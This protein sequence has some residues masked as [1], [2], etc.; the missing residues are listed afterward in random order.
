MSSIKQQLERCDGLG[1]DPMGMNSRPDKATSTT[2]APQANHYE[3]RSEERPPSLGE[4]M[5][6]RLSQFYA[7]YQATCSTASSA[8]QRIIEALPSRR[9]GI[10][11]DFDTSIP[12]DVQAALV[13]VQKAH[14]AGTRD[15]SASRIVRAWVMGFV[16]T[17]PEATVGWVRD[18]LYS[19]GNKEVSMNIT[20]PKPAPLLALPYYPPANRTA[21]NH[22]A[23][24][25]K[26]KPA[27]TP[28]PHWR[29][30]IEGGIFR[31][32][33]SS[34]QI[35]REAQ[36]RAAAERAANAALRTKV[37]AVLYPPDDNP[38][39]GFAI[40]DPDAKRG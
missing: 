28:D 26:P 24:T 11:R 37:E 4:Q 32:N 27:E 39:G 34:E 13:A 9:E 23:T 33:I 2:N 20:P 12:A 21:A 10:I 35:V 15:R 38:W 6:A 16:D 40:R 36:E 31:T 30:A 14:R 1:G 22:N 25:P 5:R 3:T 7:A 17:H 19:E 8:T 29:S 18:Q